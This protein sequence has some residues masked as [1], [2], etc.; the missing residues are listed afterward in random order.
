MN[1]WESH[2]DSSEVSLPKIKCKLSD[3]QTQPAPKQRP[4][5]FSI[6]LDDTIRYGCWYFD[7]DMPSYS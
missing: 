4:G 6:T 2:V 1:R 3:A 7:S 5:I